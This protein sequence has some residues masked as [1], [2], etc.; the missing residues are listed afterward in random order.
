MTE[1]IETAPGPKL[2]NGMLLMCGLSVD[3]RPFCL[4]FV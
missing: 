3:T 4:D 1:A 2:T